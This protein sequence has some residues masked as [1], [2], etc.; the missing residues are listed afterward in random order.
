MR[1]NYVPL[2]TFPA[3]SK[4]DK[5]TKKAS[6]KFINPLVNHGLK[7]ELLKFLQARAFVKKLSILKAKATVNIGFLLPRIFAERHKTAMTTLL[8]LHTRIVS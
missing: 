1:S 4:P 6:Q 7:T 5:K 3:R 8:W 2:L